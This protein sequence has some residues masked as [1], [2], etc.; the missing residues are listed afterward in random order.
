MRKFLGAILA[1]GNYLNAGNEKKGQ[2]DG[3]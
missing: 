3:F 2:A 1:A